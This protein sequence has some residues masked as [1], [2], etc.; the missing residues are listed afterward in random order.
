MIRRR[1]FL[2]KAGSILGLPFL[3]HGLPGRAADAPTP[4]E[5]S[6]VFEEFASNCIDLGRYDVK[7]KQL[8]VRFVGRKLERFYRYSNVTPEIWEKMRQL[9]ESG[10]VGGYLIETIVQNPKKFPFEELTVRKFTV[11]PGKKKAGTHVPAF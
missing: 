8:T 3:L 1:Q 4:S 10:G 2:A 9:N 11:T 5:G 7:A 6:L